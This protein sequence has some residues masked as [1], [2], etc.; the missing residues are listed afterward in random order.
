MGFRTISAERWPDNQ[1]GNISSSIYSPP[2]EEW[3]FRQ[4]FGT[5]AWLL[6]E[7]RKS[8]CLG[9]YLHWGEFSVVLSKFFSSPNSKKTY[10]TKSVVKNYCDSFNAWNMNVLLKCSCKSRYILPSKILELEVWGKIIDL[11]L[12]TD[13][14]QE[15]YNNYVDCGHFLLVHSISL[16]TS[17]C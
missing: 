9:N 1:P 12:S 11:I 6:W 8:R 2:K 15:N 10:G 17:E 13:F 14:L 5:H 4:F 7:G 16:N 3:R